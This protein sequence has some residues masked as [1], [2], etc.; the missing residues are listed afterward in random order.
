[1][2]ILTKLLPGNQGQ[3]QVINHFDSMYPWHGAMKMALCLWSLFLKTYNS[4]LTIKKMRQTPIEEHSTKYPIST[5][6]NWTGDQ[7]QEKS[8]KLSEPRGNW[9][10]T[11]KGNVVS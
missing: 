1:M 3:H 10:V 4:S 9:D 8:E 2:E 5:T 11:T 7:K 6:L